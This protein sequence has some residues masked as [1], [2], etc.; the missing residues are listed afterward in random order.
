M[1]AA[2]P[3]GYALIEPNDVTRYDGNGLMRK[4]ATAKAM[5][6]IEAA[7]DEVRGPDGDRWFVLPPVEHLL[8]DTD[9]AGLGTCMGI[10]YLEG[11]GRIEQHAERPAWFRVLR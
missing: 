11:E 10:A 1:S 5:D 3:A 9:G 8:F 6:L 2:L 7:L 4:L